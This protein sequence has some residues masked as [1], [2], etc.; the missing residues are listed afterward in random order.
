MASLRAWREAQEAK[1]ALVV[2]QRDALK[3]QLADAPP[4][5]IA[6]PSEADFAV[7]S[8]RSELS[9][10]K[11]AL[12][13]RERTWGEERRAL[14][15]AAMEAKIATARFESEAKFARERYEGVKKSLESVCAERDRVLKRSDEMSGLLV[16]AQSALTSRLDDLSA[17][18]GELKRLQ[19][20]PKVPP[21]S[22]LE[23]HPRRSHPA[24]RRICARSK[25]SATR[26]LRSSR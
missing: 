4:P 24:R 12:D 1:L 6:V 16:A 23:K 8:L 3:A 26:P 14:L 20:R 9:A 21:F 18:Q 5:R 17:A 25:S 13:S 15:D 2:A 22:F 11:A 10:A 19:V 7:D